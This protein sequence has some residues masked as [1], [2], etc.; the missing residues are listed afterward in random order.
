MESV[1]LA[2]PIDPEVGHG[3][4]IHI[5]TDDGGGTVDLLNPISG[6]I[7]ARRRWAAEELHNDTRHNLG[8]HNGGLSVGGLNQGLQNEETLNISEDVAI[9]NGG[10]FYFGPVKFATKIFDKDGRIVATVPTE[11]TVV[12]N[13]SPR[14]G[15]S[16]AA[17]AFSGG[18]MTV[19]F[20]PSVDL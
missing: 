10:S 17:T 13:S 11:S 9:W 12:F 3:S 7:P 14:P 5:F 2:I 8:N 18:L 20:F 4:F 6:R 19:S 16:L 15:N 1:R